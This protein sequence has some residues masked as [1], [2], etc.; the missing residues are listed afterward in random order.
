VSSRYILILFSNLC[1][2]VR[3]PVTYICYPAADI[4]SS[5]NDICY[6]LADILLPCSRHF[7]PSILCRAVSRLSLLPH[8]SVVRRT[9]FSS[10]L[11]SS[12][13]SAPCPAS[14]RCCCVLFCSIYREFLSSRFAVAPVA[15]CSSPAT[16]NRAPLIPFHVRNH[17]PFYSRSQL[18]WFRGEAPFFTCAAL[19][20]AERS[21][22]MHCENF[23]SHRAL[24]IL[25]ICAAQTIAKF[26][27]LRLPQC[28]QRVT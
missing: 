16:T 6:P 25:A 19:L 11:L 27:A 24:P 9:C 21:L 13:T 7:F 2:R 10:P 26:D 14:T 3:T 20:S 1:L 5:L 8:S 28:A 15:T 23:A 4:C 18:P 22:Q 12:C 17:G